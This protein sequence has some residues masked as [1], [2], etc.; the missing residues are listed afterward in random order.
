[1]G[2][3]IP[4]RERSFSKVILSDYHCCLF[5]KVLKNGRVE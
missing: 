2:S 5:F 3:E 4:I 1:L